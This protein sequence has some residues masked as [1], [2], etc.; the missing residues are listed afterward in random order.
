MSRVLITGA[1]GMLGSCIAS[2]LKHKHEVYLTGRQQ[3]SIEHKE[4][5]YKPKDLKDED[6]TDLITWAQPDYVVHCA[7][8]TDVRFC[9]ENPSEAYLVNSESVRKNANQIYE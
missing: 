1:N 6:Y 2:I 9:Q 5:V 4:C 3:E 7:A 8:I